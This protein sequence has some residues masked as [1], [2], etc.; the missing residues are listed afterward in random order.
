[1]IPRSLFLL[2]LGAVVPAA[3]SQ[4]PPPPPPPVV[5]A[6]LEYKF[7][8]EEGK[9]YV[10]EGSMN[11]KTWVQVSPPVFGDGQPASARLKVD[12]AEGQPRY[13]QYRAGEVDPALYGPAP[14]SL[15][16]QTLLLNDNGRE[17]QVILYKEIQG[18][19]RGVLKTDA[20][21]A[22]SF[23]YKALRTGQ[24][25]IRLELTYFDHTTAVANLR[26]FDGSLGSYQLRDYD[27]TGH[28]QGIEAG[29]FGLHS[30]RPPG[31]ADTT[32]PSTLAGTS[33][34]FTQ[35]GR[36]TRLEFLSPDEVVL[37]QED[38]SQETRSYDYDLNSPG[39]ATLRI[40]LPSGATAVYDMS[41]TAG[42]SGSFS[43]TTEPPPGQLPQ[44]GNNT[45]SNGGFDLPP[46]PTPP[47]QK[48]DCPPKSL[49][50]K[51]IVLSSS[52][53]ITLF[54]QADGTGTAVRERGGSVEVTPF[55]Y[56]YSRNGSASANLSVTFPGAATDKVDDYDLDFNPDCTGTYQNSSFNNG[57]S[58]IVSNGG[59]S[60]GGGAAGHP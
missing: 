53:P 40:S 20:T 43:Q 30:A 24:D 42:G 32:L 38:G 3:W 49:D 37:H 41:L 2:W 55:T 36:S 21:H 4:T 28:V 58:N 5:R 10:V 22:R 19:R 46:T 6:A 17:R 39:K 54:F 8:T 7:D 34:L 9:V 18:L 25:S 33:Q 44:P 47:A 45:P 48:P 27:L 16:G 29:G 59:F 50:G 35:G 23:T 60:T 13:A 12:A 51:S 15:E 31:N 52:D 11:G 14:V 1:M 56:D 57:E 26:F